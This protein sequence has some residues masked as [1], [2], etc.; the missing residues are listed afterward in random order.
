MEKLL[1]VDELSAML[2]MSPKT[3]YHWVHRGEIPYF[4]VYSVRGKHGL[5][6]FRESDIERWLQLRKQAPYKDVTTHN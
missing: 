5:V 1:K 4:K 6:R 2:Q 3:I